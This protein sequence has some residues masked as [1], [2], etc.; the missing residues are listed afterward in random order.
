MEPNTTIN[1]AGSPVIRDITTT[2][3]VADE[4]VS[5]AAP[6]AQAMG[7]MLQVKPEAGDDKPPAE[8]PAT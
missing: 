8:R 1:P 5:I 4:R 7:A 6:F 2:G 3:G